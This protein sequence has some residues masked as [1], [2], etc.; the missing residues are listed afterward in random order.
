[1]RT[2]WLYFL[3]ICVAT[4]SIGAKGIGEID[5]KKNESPSGS[6]YVVAESINQCYDRCKL[7]V[8]KQSDYEKRE[9]CLKQCFAQCEWNIK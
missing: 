5:T 8:C 1:M 3:T 4:V 9:K 7:D 2:R 6:N